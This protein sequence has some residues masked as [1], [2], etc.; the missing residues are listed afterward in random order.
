MSEGTSEAPYTTVL[1][2]QERTRIAEYLLR[3]NGKGEIVSQLGPCI[4]GAGKREWHP[5]CLKEQ[6]QK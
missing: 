4:C 1:N 6:D 3:A 2:N 5:I